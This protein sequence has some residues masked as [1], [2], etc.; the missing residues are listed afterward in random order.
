MWRGFGFGPG[1]F[2]LPL[3]ILL[4]LTIAGLIKYLRN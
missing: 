1:L 3:L 2:G 4:V